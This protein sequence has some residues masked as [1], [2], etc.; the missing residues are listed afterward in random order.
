MARLQKGVELRASPSHALPV[1][2]SIANAASADEN[3]N[4][5]NH[6]VKLCSSPYDTFPSVERTL[7]QTTSLLLDLWKVV[8]SLI[9]LFAKSLFPVKTVGSSL[10]ELLTFLPYTGDD[11]S[12]QAA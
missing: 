8:P 5:M 12:S 10:L 1:L 11:S 3:D 9:D 4:I 7:S 2:I 6:S